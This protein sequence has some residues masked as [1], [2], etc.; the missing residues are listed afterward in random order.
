M[1]SNRL[2]RHHGDEDA[3]D[4]EPVAVFGH[5]RSLHEADDQVAD[6]VLSLQRF[7]DLDELHQR[8]WIEE[9]HTDDAA[10]ILRGRGA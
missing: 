4:D 3:V 5:A 9:V 2:L 1:S 8:H 6:L 7:D 10:R